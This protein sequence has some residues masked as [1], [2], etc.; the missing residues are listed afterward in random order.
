MYTNDP[1]TPTPKLTDDGRR[2]AAL[3][4]EDDPAVRLVARLML[5]RL[6]WRVDEAADGEE[7]LTRLTPEVAPPHYDLI[8][9]D[10]RMPRMSGI[11]LCAQLF[12]MRPEVLERLVLYSGTLHDE[13]VTRF[14]ANIAVPTIAKPFSYA[15]LEAMAGRMLSKRSWV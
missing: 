5:T 7:A 14:L 2:P 13:D 8:L 15:E 9:S 4:V 11:E 6:G 12:A 10:V 1:S 3:V